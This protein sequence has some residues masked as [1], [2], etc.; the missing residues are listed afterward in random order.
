MTRKTANVIVPVRSL[1]SG[2]EAVS[3]CIWCKR[4]DT[5]ATAVTIER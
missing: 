2:F 1:G 5:V 4:L 3:V